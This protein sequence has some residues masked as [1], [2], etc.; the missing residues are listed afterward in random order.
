MY[1]SFYGLSGKPFQ[2]NPD[3]SFFFGSKGHRRALAYLEYGLHQSEGFIVI[4]G[5]IGAG[6]TTLVR[7]LLQKLDA[8]KVVAA[9]LVSTHLDAEDT[10]RLVAAAFGLPNKQLKKADLL[11]SIEMFLLSLTAAGKRALLIVDEAQNLTPRAVEELRML[12]N[13]QLGEHALLQSFLVGQPEFRET[14]QSRDMEQL[15][16]RVI[17]SYHLGPMDTAE[18]EAY[19]EHRLKHVG[20]RGSPVFQAD[21]HEAIFKAT[22]GVPRRINTLCDRLMLAG[23]LTGARSFGASDVES[24]VSE[25]RDEA[26]EKAAAAAVAKSHEAAAQHGVAHSASFGGSNLIGAPALF[27]MDLSQFKLDAESA[28]RVR[29]FV[30]AHQAGCLEDRLLRIERTLEQT[31]A[32]LGELADRSTEPVPEGSQAS[33]KDFE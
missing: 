31:I 25:I 33:R 24:V 2:L 26:G 7:S 11:L 8:K 13:F 5:E 15:R 6:K 28:Q 22:E 16:Q 20:W 10:L 29:D 21:A 14:M 30:N 9:Q 4:T 3:P 12:S 17:A 23:F 1:E 27:D 19:I 18:T 32:L